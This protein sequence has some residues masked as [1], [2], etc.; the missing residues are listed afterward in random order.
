LECPFQFFAGR[1]LALTEPPAAPAERFDGMARGSLVHHLLAQYHRLHTDLLALFENEWG[2]IQRKLRVPPSYR[3][4]VERALLERSLRMYAAATQ[5]GDRAAQRME[6]SFEFD[7]AGARIRGR[8][9]RYEIADSGACTVYDYKFSRPSSVKGLKHDEEEDRGLQ[10]G[11]YLEALQRQGL[12][13]LAF[14]YVALKGACAYYG[15]DEPEQL[16]HL[17]A[18]AVRRAERAIAEIQAGRIDVAP[19]DED[20]CAFCAFKDA[21]RIVEIGY[22]RPERTAVAGE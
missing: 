13:P 8:I 9:D 19:I 2:R 17:A 11:L 20:S 16:H 15:W 7:C 12:R 1:T 18:S 3:L 21:C 22:R 14:Y 6:D 4:E 5:L 10:A